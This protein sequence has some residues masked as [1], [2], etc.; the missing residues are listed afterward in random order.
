MK[1]LKQLAQVIGI[2]LFFILLA[3]L[4]AGLGVIAFFILK[5]AVYALFFLGIIWV[6]LQFFKSN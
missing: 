4:M 1:T 6:I 5:V 3:S 2:I